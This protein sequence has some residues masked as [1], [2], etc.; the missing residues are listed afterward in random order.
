MKEHSSQ[1]RGIFAALLLALIAGFNLHAAD[2]KFIVL[3]KGQRWMQ[4]NSSAATLVPDSNHVFMVSV[5]ASGPE[6]I[7]NGSLVLPNASV[8]PLEGDGHDH[9]GLEE[10]FV[11]QSTMDVAYPNG[12]YQVSS[13]G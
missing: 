8:V 7:T 3:A 12:T 6:S 4:T 5:E 9:G 13:K 10:L 1:G 2:A 11:S